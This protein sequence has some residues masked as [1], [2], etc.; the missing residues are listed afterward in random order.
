MRKSHQPLGVAHHKHDAN[1]SRESEEDGGGGDAVHA[2]RS[3]FGAK[4]SS[5]LGGGAAIHGGWLGGDVGMR[6][7]T[8]AQ[9]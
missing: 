4:P 9:Q 6:F 1:N 2:G 5:V 7:Y 8:R 3:P